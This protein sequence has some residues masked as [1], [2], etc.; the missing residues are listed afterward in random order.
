[1]L[2]PKGIYIDRDLWNHQ[3]GSLT[4]QIH[5]KGDSMPRKKKDAATAA[6]LEPK[7]SFDAPDEAHWHRLI[8]E[9]AY[10]LAEQRGFAQGSEDE[11]WL[12]AE[13]IVR[14]KLQGD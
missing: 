11:D 5:T 10:Y 14:A 6:K 13:A 9:A 12:R 3:H 8:S 4:R 1:M 7:S 2:P